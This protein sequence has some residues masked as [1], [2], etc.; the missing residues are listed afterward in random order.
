MD[1]YVVIKNQSYGCKREPKFRKSGIVLAYILPIYVYLI[2]EY[3]HFKDAGK[4]FSFIGENGGAVMFSLTA[5]YGLYA[6]L[7]LIFKRG[8]FA[9]LTFLV[10]CFSLGVANYYKFALRSENIYPWE[11]FTQLGNLGALTDFVKI[12]FP[13]WYGLLLAVGVGALIILFI[14]KTSL[15]VK[16]VPRFTLAILLV[17]L[18]SISVCTQGMAERTLKLYNMS[19]AQTA[20]QDKNYNENGFVG[21]FLLNTLSMDMETPEEYSKN[22]IEKIM[23]KYDGERGKN[24]SS[25]DVIVVLSESFWNPKLLPGTTFSKNPTANFDEIA[26]RENSV[27][28][29]MY[30]TAFAGGTVR[31]EYEV[32]TGLSCDEIPAG[33]VPWQYVEEEIPTYATAFKNLGYSTT[34]LHTYTSDFYLRDKTYPLLGFDKTYFEDDLKKIGE[35][36]Q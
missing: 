12:G 30:Q 33:A 36:P 5:L 4:L 31:T 16:V 13:I 28:G 23:D 27:S 9:S 11:T 32:I 21:G 24:F 10:I 1:K 29:Y 22:S 25:P 35:V 6:L 17:L 26:S 18:M 20:N 14:S 34:F 15:P 8:F 3:I 7:W 2:T 19:V